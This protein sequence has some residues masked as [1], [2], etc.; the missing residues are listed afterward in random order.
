M[1]KKT[2]TRESVKELLQNTKTPLSA[3]EIFENLKDNNITLSSIYRTL[4]A[5]RRERIVIKTTDNKGIAIYTL[6][7]EDHLHYLEC[8]N[9]H[10]KTNLDYCPYH[11]VNAQ[12]RS[13]HNFQVDEHNVVIYGLCEKC[14]T[15]D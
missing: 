11:K 7:N 12:I 3:N 13:K 9:C 10:S 8:T 4:E 5:F 1:L 2:H 15:K 6:N 14:N